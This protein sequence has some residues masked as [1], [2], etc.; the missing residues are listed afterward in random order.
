[1]NTKFSVL[2]VFAKDADTTQPII[3]KVIW[4]VIFSE[5]GVESTGAGE[6]LLPAPVNGEPFTPIDQVTEDQ[7]IQWV[8]AQEGGQEFVD[9]LIAIHTPA[10][11][12][13]KRQLGLSPVTMSFISNKQKLLADALEKQK[14]AT[15]PSFVF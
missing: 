7:I 14:A 6:T 8:I 13:K 9:R 10:L 2:Q 3:A 11:E 4:Q 15:I 1:M 5:D 12:I